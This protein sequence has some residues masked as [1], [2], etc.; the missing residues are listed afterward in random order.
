MATEEAR[1]WDEVSKSEDQVD[2]GAGAF[3]AVSSKRNVFP[4]TNL[5]FHSATHTRE[6]VRSINVPFRL[7]TEDPRSHF[8]KIRSGDIAENRKINVVVCEV[9]RPPQVILHNLDHSTNLKSDQGQHSDQ[10]RYN[11]VDQQQQTSFQ[12]PRGST[13]IS[14][15]TPL[16]WKREA[17]EEFLSRLARCYQNTFGLGF[18]WSFFSSIQGKTRCRQFRLYERCS[19]GKR[20]KSFRSRSGST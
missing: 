9:V 8:P 3:V 13:W 18:V 10:W 2:V 19:I 17:R 12:E 4:M 15:H 11:L 6:C 7:N 16:N 5:P 1:A 14:S 20:R